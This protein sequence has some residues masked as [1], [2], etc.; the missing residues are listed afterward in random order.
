MEAGDALYKSCFSGLELLKYPL[1]WLERLEHFLLHCSLFVFSF[2][3]SYLLS[4]MAPGRVDGYIDFK[5][6]DH[7]SKP[8]ESPALIYARDV[9]PSDSSVDEDVSKEGLKVEEGLAMTDVTVDGIAMEIPAAEKLR[10]TLTVKEQTATDHAATLPDDVS[11]DSII[12]DEGLAVEDTAV[13]GIAKEISTSEKPHT[14]NDQTVTDNA[15]TL[16]LLEEPQPAPVQPQ[17]NE[18]PARPIYDGKEPPAPKTVKEISEDVVGVLERYRLPHH[19]DVSQAWGAKSKFLVQVEQRV[20]ESEAVC[21]VLP[22]FPFK[23][24]NKKTKVLGDLPDK[25]EEVALQHLDGLCR[26]IEDVYPGGA[27]LYI[28]SDG[29]MYNGDI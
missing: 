1:S 12:V 10:V 14:V 9:T 13:D 25:G 5:V 18:E 7:W 8:V 17:V 27:K 19:S 29:L 11:K 3:A 28:V 22:A 21:M 6:P 20:A 23:S 4:T 2:Q 16:S 26:A 24:P 15:V